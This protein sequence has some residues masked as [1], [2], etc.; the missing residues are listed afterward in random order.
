TRSKRDW[1]SDVCSSDLN[2]E[3]LTA[4]NEKYAFLLTDKQDLVQ[5]PKADMVTLVEARIAQ[6]EAAMKAESERLA[7][8]ERERI[9]AEEEAKAREAARKEE[10]KKQEAAE[11][12]T[13][14]VVQIDFDEENV[15]AA[16]LFET[17]FFAAPNL[18]ETTITITRK[19]YVDLL[20]TKEFLGALYDAGLSQWKG[21]EE[22]LKKVS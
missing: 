18:G 15:T 13:T 4:Y 8:Q 10:A 21:Y 16:R 2:L 1:S 19:E 9:R 20:A 17:A 14:G 22:A 7:E 11:P 12:K 6:H 5:K 3:V